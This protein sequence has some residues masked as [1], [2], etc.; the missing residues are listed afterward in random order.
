MEAMFCQRDLAQTV[1]DSGGD[2]ILAVKDNQPELKADLQAAFGFEGA[3]RG[4]AAAFSPGPGPGAGREDGIDRGQGA[5]P[6][7]ASE[8]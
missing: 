2:Y 7:G 8:G 3:S 6:P 4:V 5:L 1:V